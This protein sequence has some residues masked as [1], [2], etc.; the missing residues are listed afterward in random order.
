MLPA[1]RR[2]LPGRWLTDSGLPLRGVSVIVKGTTNATVTD[3]QGNYKIEVFPEDKILV[4]T[5]IGYTTV[6]E[7]IGE[8]S[9]INVVMKVVDLALDEIVVIGY[10]TKKERSSE[11][12]FNGGAIF[13]SLWC[14][15]TLFR[16]IM[17]ILILKD[18]PE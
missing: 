4:F 8:R 10:G 6:S 15:S 14:E 11:I 2:K 12:L 9:L 3:Q 13:C 1:S 5:M 18:M 17:I 7:K 16:G